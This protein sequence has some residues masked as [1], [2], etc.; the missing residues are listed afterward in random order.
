MW[1]NNTLTLRKKDKQE[2]MN[3]DRSLTRVVFVGKW[4]VYVWR[5]VMNG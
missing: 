4:C 1:G 5:W 3:G 2:I